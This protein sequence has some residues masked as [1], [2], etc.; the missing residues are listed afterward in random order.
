MDIVAFLTA[1]YDER[2]HYARRALN[3][4]RSGTE[5]TG[6]RIVDGELAIR[7]SAMSAALALHFV[8]LSPKDVLS[9]VTAK[10]RIVEECY[11]ARENWRNGAGIMG[12]AEE[13]ARA[14]ERRDALTFVA[15][16]LA[17]PYANHPDY[18][19]TWAVD[20]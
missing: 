15:R 12:T 14:T 19:P 20:A 7:P 2:E 10:R 9:D 18:D 17:A 16:V 5:G 1:R 3:D 13:V 6:V 11:A 4:S 8:T